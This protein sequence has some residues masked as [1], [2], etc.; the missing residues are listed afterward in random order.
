MALRN[1]ELHARNDDDALAIARAKTFR[2][3]RCSFCY[4]YL[5]FR[6]TITSTIKCCSVVFGVNVEVSCHT[7]RRRLP[8]STNSDAYQRLVSSTRYGPS[9]LSVLALHLAAEPF[10][11]F[12]GARTDICSQSRFVPTPHAFDTPVMVSPTEYCHNV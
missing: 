4:C 7:R 1:R 3:Y 6:F 11:A 8:P 12:D 10:A 5:G 2:Y 9:Q